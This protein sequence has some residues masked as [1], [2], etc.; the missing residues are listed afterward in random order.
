MSSRFK[1]PDAEENVACNLIPMIDIMFLLLLFF[2]LG[3]DM[4]QRELE[5][6][7][8][9]K[10]DQAKQESDFK[11]PNAGGRTTVNVFHRHSS[12]GVTECAAFSSGQVCRNMDHWMMAIRAKYETLDTIVKALEEEAKLEIEEV[13]ANGKALSKRH[14]HIRADENAPYGYI[15]RVIESCAAVGIYRIE[16]AAAQPEPAG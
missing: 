13:D 6:V 8:L 15:Q 5:D 14:V 10:A 9:P 2:M 1:G 4:T 16:V 11:D 7:V 3:A 12:T